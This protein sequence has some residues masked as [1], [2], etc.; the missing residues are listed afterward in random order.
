MKARASRARGEN[1]RSAAA[2]PSSAPAK[3]GSDRLWRIGLLSAGRGGL[4]RRSG[5][6]FR[7]GPLTIFWRCEGAALSFRRG[8][9]AVGNKPSTV[10]SED[11][12]RRCG[13]AESQQDI[14]SS[15]GSGRCRLSR[16][17]SGCDPVQPAFGHP[18]SCYPASWRASASYRP[19]SA[20]WACLPGHSGVGEITSPV[21]RSD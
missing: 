13:N 2:S 10:L 21:Q 15:R 8:G 18:A 16:S 4:S 11:A 7:S 1:R 6:L 5:I 17:D 9:C 3:P 19:L 20:V 14:R 12:Y